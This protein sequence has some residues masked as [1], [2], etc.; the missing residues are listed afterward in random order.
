MS[1]SD[2][3]RYFKQRIVS[4]SPDRQE[5]TDTLSIANVQN[6]PSTLL[7]SRYH[8]EFNSLSSTNQLDVTVTD[9]A[10]VI[11]SIWKQGFNLP[12]D[13]KDTLLDEAEQIRFSLV[14]PKNVDLFN[15]PTHS[16]I[17]RVDMVSLT[18]SEI[19]ESND[20]IVQVQMDFVATLIC[21]VTS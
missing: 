11:V 19:D 13:A 18:P 20:N 12:Q 4:V 5:W 7:D 8:I 9:S 21:G 16:G 6:V 1:Y 15:T 3:R 2:V 14:N 10:S 17:Q